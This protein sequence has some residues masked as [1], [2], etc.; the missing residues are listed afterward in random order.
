MRN[1]GGGETTHTVTSVEDLKIT[2][3]DRLQC[4]KKCTVDTQTISNSSSLLNGGINQHRNMRQIHA[5][6]TTKQLFWSSLPLESSSYHDK[7]SRDI[8]TALSVSAILAI[9]PRLI[10]LVIA[11]PVRLFGRDKR[12]TSPN[13]EYLQTVHPLEQ[14][15][16]VICLTDWLRSTR[17]SGN[18]CASC[19]PDNKASSHKA[20]F[21]SILKTC[22]IAA[23]SEAPHVAALTDC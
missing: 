19:L 9:V 15:L 18:R 10:H 1:Q 12:R 16:N 13:G 23:R 14:T 17:R 21:T 5:G 7:Y 4:T 6:A 8:S 11:I 20:M 22:S 2:D 3:P